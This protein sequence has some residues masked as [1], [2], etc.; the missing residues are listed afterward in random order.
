MT[1]T[2]AMTLREDNKGDASG[3]GCGSDSGGVGDVGMK[4]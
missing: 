3:R 1:T 2:E 4:V